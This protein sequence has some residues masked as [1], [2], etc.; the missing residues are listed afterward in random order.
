MN[1]IHPNKIKYKIPNKI[2]FRNFYRRI[3]QEHPYFI[4]PQIIQINAVFFCVIYELII[5]ANRRNLRI[6]YQN[7]S[8]LR[9]KS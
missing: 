9:S 3:K 1:T 4:S 8:F 2:Y 5:C 6:R 7:Y